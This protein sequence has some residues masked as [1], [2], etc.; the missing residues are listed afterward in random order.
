MPPTVPQ[1]VRLGADAYRGLIPGVYNPDDIGLAEYERMR[2]DT[3]VKL[4]YR[5]VCRSTRRR[6]GAY[7]HERPEVQDWAT[8]YVMPTVM[9]DCQRLQTAL[10]YGVAVAAPR[11]HLVG[12]ELALAEVDICHPSR[13][14][15][16]R[17]FM[18]DDSGQ[19]ASLD[20]APLGHVPVLSPETGERQLVVYSSDGDFDSPWGEPAAK[21]AY[22]FWFIKTRLIGFEAMGAERH[23]LGTAVFGVRDDL[24]T[25]EGQPRPSQAYCDAWADMGTAAAMAIDAED[26]LSVVTPGWQTTS[27]FDGIIRRL[28]ASIFNAFYLPYL[29]LAEANFG[30][31]AQASVA[32][33]AYLAA[34][35]DMAEELADQVLIDQIIGPAVRA[36]FGPGTE[37]GDLPI[38]DASPPDREAWARILAMLSQ[39]G[40]FDATIEEQLKWAGNLFELPVDELVAAGPG[41]GAPA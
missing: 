41:P 25:A 21:A 20:I 3:S 33:E 12:S 19:L 36:R 11:Y 18:R 7:R 31:R 1:T 40:V 34:E 38:R 29:M 22:P 39:S 27:P 28:D 8:T 10:Y 4:A 35:T 32:L 37:S 30:T 5:Y 9:R 26:T 16:G 24:P 14:W 15:Y 23:G 17:G 13:Y 6:I 2:R